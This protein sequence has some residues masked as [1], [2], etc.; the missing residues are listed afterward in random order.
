MSPG[1]REAGAG[2][3]VEEERGPPDGI[4]VQRIAEDPSVPQ[5]QHVVGHRPRADSGRIRFGGH[6]PTLTSAIIWPASWLRVIPQRPPA[7]RATTEAGSASAIL[8][9][10]RSIFLP[11]PRSRAQ[12]CSWTTCRSCHRTRLR[13]LPAPARRQ[14]CN[15]NQLLLD[16]KLT[17]LKYWAVGCSS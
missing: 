13:E 8:R 9:F 12:D 11:S 17:W 16:G 10:V 6:R 3:A 2:H 7:R 1:R 14:P 4:A 5:A 15:R